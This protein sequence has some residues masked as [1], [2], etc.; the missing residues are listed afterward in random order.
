M[1]DSYSPILPATLF[2]SWYLPRS[3]HQSIG[4]DQSMRHLSTFRWAAAR[5]QVLVTPYITV[6]LKTKPATNI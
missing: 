5:L 2:L 1:L 6:S 4:L 3:E